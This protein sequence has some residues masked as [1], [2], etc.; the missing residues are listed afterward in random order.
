MFNYTATVI[1]PEVKILMDQTDSTLRIEAILL[2]GQNK[3]TSVCCKT[4]AARAL[5]VSGVDMLPTLWSLTGHP[6]NIP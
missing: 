5:T 2:Q 1:S 3:F 6:L 4:Q